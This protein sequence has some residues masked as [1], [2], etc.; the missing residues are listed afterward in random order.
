MKKDLTKM[1]ELVFTYTAVMEG[2]LVATVP[3]DIT[4]QE[5]GG[6]AE[7]L[8][9]FVKDWEEEADNDDLELDD[10]REGGLTED[11]AEAA[12]RRGPDGSLAVRTG[13]AARSRG[14]RAGLTS[15]RRVARALIVA[16]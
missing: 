15:L 2:H 11:E 8:S 9:V 3:A 16:R 12:V 1:V 4:C 10:I 7:D 6:L 5:L 13:R 14:D